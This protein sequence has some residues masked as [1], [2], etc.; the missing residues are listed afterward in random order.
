MEEMQRQMAAFYN[1]LRPGS[2]ATTGG[3]GTSTAPPLPPRPPP[4]PPPQQP[5]HDDDGDD[6]DYKDAI[7][8]GEEEDGGAGKG[9]SSCRR[10]ERQRARGRVVVTHRPSPLLPLLRVVASGPLH[11]HFSPRLSSS[12]AAVISC[13]CQPLVAPPLLPSLASSP[14]F[15]SLHIKLVS[16]KV[17]KT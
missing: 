5:D 10:R 4:P 17:L 12:P 3:S 14:A 8:G 6:D 9:R 11:L 1:P 7:E 13:R 16:L 2:S 15:H